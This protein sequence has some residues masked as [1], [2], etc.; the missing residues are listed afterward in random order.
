MNAPKADDQRDAYFD[1]L[2]RDDAD[3]WLVRQRW[4]EERKRALLLACLPSAATGA[5]LSRFAQHGQLAAIRHRRL[6]RRVR[7]EQR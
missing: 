5:P 6:A 1:Q 4:Y 7:Q 3:P 2:Y